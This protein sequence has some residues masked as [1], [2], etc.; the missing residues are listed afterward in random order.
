[1]KTNINFRKASFKDFEKVILNFLYLI[2]KTYQYDSNLDV[3]NL[4]EKS[5]K[6]KAR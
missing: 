6:Q 4:K 2:A 5:N 1:M 3:K